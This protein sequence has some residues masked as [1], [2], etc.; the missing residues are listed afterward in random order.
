MNPFKFLF[1]KKPARPKLPDGWTQTQI[2][3]NTYIT[4]IPAE[5]KRKW[6]E[7]QRK[8]DLIENLLNKDGFYLKLSGRAGMVYYVEDE[9]I[10]EFD[11]EISGV[12][13]Y[14]FLFSYSDLNNWF[15]PQEL[16]MT[17]NKKEEIKLKFIEWLTN[18]K[19]KGKVY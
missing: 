7:D 19:I 17:A 10:C 6:K 5:Q 2:S 1:A 11:F 13:K 3:E 15:F 12:P 4:N 8:R 9:K 14:N 16:Q 18:K